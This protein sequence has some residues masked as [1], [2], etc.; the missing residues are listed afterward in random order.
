MKLKTL[1]KHVIFYTI[2]ALILRRIPATKKRGREHHPQRPVPPEQGRNQEEGAGERG[3][4]EHQ[5]IKRKG[6]EADQRI[7]E[8]QKMEAKNT[9]EPDQYGHLNINF[10]FKF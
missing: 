3:P 4:T 6:P 1:I 7:D 2:F 8:R 5:D 10:S 9:P